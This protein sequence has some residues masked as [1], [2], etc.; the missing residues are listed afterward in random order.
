MAFPGE[1]EKVLKPCILDAFLPHMSVRL[2]FAGR[3]GV[4][5]VFISLR[6][7]EME[8]DFLS[9]SVVFGRSVKPHSVFEKKKIIQYTLVN[10]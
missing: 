8:K 3:E 2:L 9:M 4:K 5:N 6:E 10:L 1:L 7:R